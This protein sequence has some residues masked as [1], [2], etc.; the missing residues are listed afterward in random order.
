M[1]LQQWSRGRFLKLINIYNID[2]VQT[3]PV[4]E[5][6]YEIGQ[7]VSK[8]IETIVPNTQDQDQEWIEMKLVRNDFSL[9][10][11]LRTLLL[12]ECSVK[13]VNRS[14]SNSTAGLM[15][16]QGSCTSSSKLLTEE[17]E[18]KMKYSVT[19][20]QLKIWFF[21]AHLLIWEKRFDGN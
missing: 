7:E 2:G 12:D 20:E 14:W 19:S 9:P 11:I 4:Q 10:G 13:T 15:S 17:L 3:L 21:H 18:K 8:T 6:S 5:A 16:K 1:K